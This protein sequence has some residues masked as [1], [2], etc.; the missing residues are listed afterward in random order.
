M[1]GFLNGV[2]LTATRWKDTATGLHVEYDQRPDV[3]RLTFLE[4]FSYYVS[5]TSLA[6]KQI[7]TLESI[8]AMDVYSLILF[9]LY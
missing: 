2:S 4:R 3:F 1:Y 6:F 8:T 9:S 7:K 5:W